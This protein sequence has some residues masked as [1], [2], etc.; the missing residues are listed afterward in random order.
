MQRALVYKE[1]NDLK[2]AEVEHAT[3]IL[4]VYEVERVPTLKVQNTPESVLWVC[5]FLSSRHSRIISLLLQLLN[6]MH[7]SKKNY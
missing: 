5:H 2:W 1:Q 3:V 6:P 7:V 4:Q